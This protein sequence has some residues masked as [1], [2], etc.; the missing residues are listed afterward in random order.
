MKKPK[1]KPVAPAAPKASTPKGNPREAAMKEY[2][3]RKMKVDTSSSGGDCCPG[4]V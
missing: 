2:N 1:M 4:G 3:R